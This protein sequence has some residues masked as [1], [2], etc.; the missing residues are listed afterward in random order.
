MKKKGFFEFGPYLFD[1]RARLLY[2]D[3]SPVPTTLKVLQ[4]LAV[5]VE[6]QTSLAPGSRTPVWQ[7]LSNLHNVE[8]LSLE[9]EPTLEL[10]ECCGSWMPKLKRLGLLDPVTGEPCIVRPVKQETQEQ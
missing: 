2:R 9:C 4:T 3:G 5:L 7:A 6:N 8:H 10:L 1:P